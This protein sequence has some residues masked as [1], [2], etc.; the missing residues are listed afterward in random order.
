M[1]IH[2]NTSA[3]VLVGGCLALTAALVALLTPGSD[4]ARETGS[5]DT[6]RFIGLESACPYLRP[7][8]TSSHT[9]FLRGLYQFGRVA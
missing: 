6:L 1:V 9:N 8:L 2:E 4:S 5:A 3:Y 7:D